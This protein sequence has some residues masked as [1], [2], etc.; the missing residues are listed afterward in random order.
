MQ[1]IQYIQCGTQIRQD[2]CSQCR[3]QIPV[4]IPKAHQQPGL[5]KILQRPYRQIR[6]ICQVTSL[7]RCQQTVFIRKQPVTDDTGSQMQ[8]IQYIQIHIRRNTV[9]FHQ[10][11]QKRQ[12]HYSGQKDPQTDQAV[13]SAIQ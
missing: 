8:Q 3:Q 7:M 6:L 4:I 9:R 11:G 12:Q 1:Q 2:L 5:Y 10:R 13:I